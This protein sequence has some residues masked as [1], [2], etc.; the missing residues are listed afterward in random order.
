MADE[1]NLSTRSCRSRAWGFA[2]SESVWNI[3]IDRGYSPERTPWY[4]APQTNASR[5]AIGDLQMPV[6]RQAQ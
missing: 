4:A 1:L 5:G 6:I 3:Q 2:E